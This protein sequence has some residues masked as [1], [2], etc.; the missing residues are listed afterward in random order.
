MTSTGMLGLHQKALWNFENIW[1]R[2]VKKYRLTPKN[3]FL[4]TESQIMILQTANVAGSLITRLI[5]LTCQ[6]FLFPFLPAGAHVAA[7]SERFKT[8]SNKIRKRLRWPFY[9][10][11]S[12]R[13]ERAATPVQRFHSDLF[14]FWIMWLWKSLS[15]AGVNGQCLRTEMRPIMDS[16]KRLTSHR[17][18]TRS[19]SVRV[20]TIFGQ[21]KK[22]EIPRD[23]KQNQKQRLW[24]LLTLLKAKTSAWASSRWIYSRFVAWD[25]KDK[26]WGLNR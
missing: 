12:R 22:K 8:I 14:E 4:V 10:K 21:E 17:C 19:H 24:R 11:R 13:R 1:K 2:L 26:V 7:K 3:E 6:V 20:R 9:T 15:P 18:D 16:T 23:N 25:L 5:M